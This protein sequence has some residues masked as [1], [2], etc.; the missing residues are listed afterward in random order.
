MLKKLFHFL[1]FLVFCFAI[2]ASA[3]AA[4]RTPETFI[5]GDMAVSCS[6]YNDQVSVGGVKCGDDKQKIM[7]ALGNPESSY[8]DNG[9]HWHYDGISIKFVDYDGSGH[10]VACDITATNEKY[11]TP[12]GVKVGMPAS[13][14]TEIYGEA[15]VV[16][17]EEFAAPK[18]SH[19]QNRF[20]RERSSTVYTYHAAPC[21][22]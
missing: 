22:P 11:A 16:R 15:D 17:N 6:I 20:Y 2:G 12:D 9:D 1:T 7:D 3:D 4:K 5:F 21:L 19:E 14:L 10:P 18:L 8:M 13:V